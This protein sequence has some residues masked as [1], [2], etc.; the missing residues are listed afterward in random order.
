MT[1]VCHG[2]VNFLLFSIVPF[3][4]PFPFLFQLSQSDHPFTERRWESLLHLGL[5]RPGQFHQLQ[6]FHTAHYFT[7]SCC[8]HAVPLIHELGSGFSILCR[9]S[10]PWI[11]LHCLHLLYSFCFFCLLVITIKFRPSDSK[12]NCLTIRTPLC[13]S[14]LCW[15]H[16]MGR[17][18]TSRLSS[19]TQSCC[20]QAG[21]V[22]RR[23]E[24][25]SDRLIDAYIHT[26]VYIYMVI[27]V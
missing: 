27:M 5:E 9:S 3:L 15:F 2:H 7:G 22:E 26:V 24:I 25:V 12:S 23:D 20:Y 10:L 19:S 16:L 21:C 17:A 11:T 6:F 1:Q 18:I 8:S 14:R 13:L 4:P